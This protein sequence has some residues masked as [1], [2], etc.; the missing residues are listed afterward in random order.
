[1]FT[2]K[3]L[4]FEQRI[5]LHLLKDYDMSVLYHICKSNVVA[6]ALSRMTMGNVTHVEEGKKDP[7]EK[8]P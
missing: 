1:M 7:S 2:Q 4:N 8:Y 6:Y 5:L 3:D